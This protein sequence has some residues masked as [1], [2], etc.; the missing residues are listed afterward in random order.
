MGSFQASTESGKQ[1]MTL[2]Y[3]QEGALDDLF[4]GLMSID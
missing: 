4:F 3:F 2:L 1:G